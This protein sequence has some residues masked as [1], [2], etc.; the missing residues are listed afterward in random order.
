MLISRVDEPMIKELRA[1]LDQE[2]HAY[3]QG[4]SENALSLSVDFHRRLAQMADNSV[5]QGYLDDIIHR[6]P[7]VILTHLGSDEQN[8]CRNQEHEAIVDAIANRDTR[9][10]CKIMNQHLLHIESK[11]K[12]KPELPQTDL[13]SILMRNSAG[14]NNA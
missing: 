7:L 6:T 1:L 3:R 11:I 2:Q 9:K 8:R 4:K 12:H 14:F 5:L 10:A 13:A